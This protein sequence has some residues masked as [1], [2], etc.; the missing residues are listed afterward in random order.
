MSIDVIREDIRAMRAY[1]VPVLD[2]DMIKLDAMEVP[3]LL[4]EQL[5]QALAEQLINAK[6]NRYPNPAASGLQDALRLAFPI[7]SDAKIALGNGSDEL[8]QLITQLVA[9][10]DRVV[11]SIEP[12]FVMYQHNAQLFGM[13]YVSV[14]LNDDLSL[15]IEAVLAAIAEHQPVLIFIAYPNNPTG[16]AFKREEVERIIQAA[17]GLVVIDEAYGAFAQDSFLPQAGQPEHLLVLRTLSKIGFAG[18]RIGYVSGSPLVINELAKIVPPYNMN[19]LSLTA[20]KFALQHI[21]VVYENVAI[22]KGERERISQTLVKLPDVNVFASEANFVTVR[23]PKA[24]QAFETLKE[25]KILVKKLSGSHPL[26]NNCLRLTVGAPDENDKVLAVLSEHCQQ[27]AA[28]QS[29]I[30]PLMSSLLPRN[31]AL[32]KWLA[33]GAALLVIAIVFAII[34]FA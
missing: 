29:S 5:Q 30:V 4:P 24:A 18:L 3:Y 16:V 19:Q 8:I 1:A 34:Y 14:P 13:N 12:T 2:K 6:I 27:C 21:D 15:N 7:P 26:L 25:N 20:A 31:K 28:E 32:Y 10:P 33:V 22:L 9:K 23:L 17:T 11:L